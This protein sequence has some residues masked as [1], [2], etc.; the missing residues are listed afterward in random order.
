[1]VGAVNIMN[2][3]THSVSIVIIANIVEFDAMRY[4]KQYND[5]PQV[6]VSRRTGNSIQRDNF[7]AMYLS[8]RSS[9]N[10]KLIWNVSCTKQRREWTQLNKKQM[11]FILI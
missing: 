6:L 11:I 10:Y 5:S 1:M 3:V 4:K 2:T 7:S 8:N 9:W